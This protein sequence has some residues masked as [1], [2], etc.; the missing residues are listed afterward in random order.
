MTMKRLFYIAISVV[1]LI[2]CGCNEEEDIFTPQKESII[3]YL[4]SSRRLVAEDE[5]GNVI[6]EQPPFYTQFGQSVYRHIPNYYEEGRDEWSVIERG[7]TVQIAFDA[8]IFSGSEPSE[9]DLYWSNIPESISAVESNSKNPYA[10]LQW[11]EEPLTI[12]LGRTNIISGIETA[13]IGCRDQ[14]SVQVYMAYTA[15]YNKAKV[16]TVPKRSPIAW[17]IKIL[18]VSK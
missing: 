13:L 2:C 12:T 8:Y 16:G 1:A 10:D 5:V 4:T 3:R 7:N 17:Y 11:S 6:E 14:D 9:K 15:A 18:N